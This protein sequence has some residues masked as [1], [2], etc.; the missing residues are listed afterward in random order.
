MKARDRLSAGLSRPKLCNTETFRCPAD[1]GFSSSMQ[2]VRSKSTG[3]SRIS[4]CG[5]M[6]ADRFAAACELVPA[7]RWGSH[8][9]SG[10]S[11]VVRETLLLSDSW[12]LHI[13]SLV[14][15]FWDSL[16]GF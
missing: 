7:T 3:K 11:R 16:T 1:L 8:R 15:P 2:K 12:W 9:R 5:A 10:V 13:D 6:S 4:E 14:V